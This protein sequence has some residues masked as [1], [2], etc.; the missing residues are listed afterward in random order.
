M[1]ARDKKIISKN[2]QF[3]EFCW[4]SKQTVEF[5]MHFSLITQLS[6]IHRG[7]WTS[8]SISPWNFHYYFELFSAENEKVQFNSV[9]F[10]MKSDQK[11]ISWWKIDKI[12][13]KMANFIIHCDNFPSKSSKIW[14]ML[15]K[16]NFHGV[17]GSLQALL[18]VTNWHGY[19]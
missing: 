13:T 7:F 3:W 8:K 11:L 15:S 4:F 10:N 6:T 14:W 5:L 1:R 18:Y 12:N 17:K 2:G 9:Y 19:S 16:T